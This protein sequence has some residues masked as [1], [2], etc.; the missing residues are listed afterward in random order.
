MPGAA[1]AGHL[2]TQVPG[3]LHREGPH[4]ARGADDQDVLAR[5]DPSCAQSLQ[6]GH[7]GQRHGG[8]LLEGEIPRLG[9]EAVLGD[10]DVLGEGAVAETVHLIARLERS[11]GAAGPLHRSGEVPARDRE[12]RFADAPQPRGAEQ[13]RLAA[14]EVP[15]PRVGRASTHRHQHV[16]RAGDR[17]LHLGQVA[18]HPAAPRTGAG[19]SPS[20]RAPSRAVPSHPPTVTATGAD[21]VS[22]SGGRALLLT[23]TRSGYRSAQGYSR[24]APSVTL[25]GAP[26][27]ALP[28]AGS[29]ADHPDL[30]QA[31]AMPSR[32]AR[33]ADRRLWR[34]SASPPTPVPNGT[35]SEYRSAGH[36]DTRRSGLAAVAVGARQVR[37]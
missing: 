21:Q 28:S 35:E 16:L 34:A 27:P 8:G 29:R 24:L 9:R 25:K 7:R 17:H 23:A 26:Y 22:Q 20:W 33:H 15:V 5:L 14:D 18:G 30:R 11:D 3:D 37:R 12:L 1:D 2:G 13:E 4:A 19:R 36:P 6:R 31:Q 32:F 10:G